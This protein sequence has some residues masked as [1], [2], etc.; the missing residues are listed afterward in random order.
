MAKKKD[1][2]SNKAK[3]ASMVRKAQGGFAKSSIYREFG[4]FNPKDVDQRSVVSA[5]RVT[6][7]RAGKSPNTWASRLVSYGGKSVGDVFKM[8]GKVYRITG[9]GY[10][11]ATTEEV[12]V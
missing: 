11:G 2:K 5:G 9:S 3:I 7:T 6:H 1:K 12:V 10:R 4:D 8:N